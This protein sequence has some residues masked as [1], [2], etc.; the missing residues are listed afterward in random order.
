MSILRTMRSAAR[1]SLAVLTCVA[2][3][4]LG[5]CADDSGPSGDGKTVTFGVS[6]TAPGGNMLQ[7]AVAQAQGYFEEEGITV[8]PVFLGAGGKVVQALASDKVQIGTATP[9]LVLQATEKGQ[10]IRMFYNWTFT[11]VTQFAVLPDSPVK[12]IADL[13]GKTVGVQDLSS[14]PTQVAKAAAV[15]AGLDPNRDLKFVAVGSGAPALDALKRHRVDVLVAYDT[16]FAAMTS[17]TGEE[18]RLFQPEYIKDLFASSLTAQKEW[19]D[20]NSDVAAA[21]GRAWAKA[22]VYAEANPEASIEM[23]F[24]RYPNSKVGADDDAAMKAAM[25]QFTIRQ[26]SL[27]GGGEPPAEQ[28]WGEY[29]EESVQKWID[30]AT[31]HKLVG[32]GIK[33]DQVY[34]NELV[35]KFNDFDPEKIK[36]AAKS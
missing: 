15:K 30:F 10:D 28:T 5:A 16:L 24:Q 25:A 20:E 29:S 11:N 36:K 31:E 4:A 18:L 9:D 12:S 26:Q 34:T 3:A 23:M 14:G 13:K 6:A 22:S 19:L 35:E 21:F 8:R 7:L 32:P 1:L 33:P 27:Y 17:G 2:T